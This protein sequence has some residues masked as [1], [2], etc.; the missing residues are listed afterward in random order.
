M[1]AFKPKNVY[2]VGAHCTGKTTLVAALKEY[3]TASQASLIHDKDT[4]CPVFID[5]VVR[6]VMQREGFIASDVKHPTIGPSLQHRTLLTQ[7]CAEKALEDQWFIADRSGI[8]P[9]VYASVFLGRDEAEKLAGGPEWKALRKSM[10]DAVVFLC[11]T[12]HEAW[13]SNDPKVRVT[14]SLEEWRGIGQGFHDALEGY[15]IPYVT[16]PVDVWKVEDRVR[17][18][19]NVLRAKA[20]F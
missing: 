9:I 15:R 7:Y 19:E 3:L 1:A 11:G 18:I 14:V 13:L 16:V 2:I 12:H 17:H 8:D 20:L 4:P 5:E 10:Q 6:G